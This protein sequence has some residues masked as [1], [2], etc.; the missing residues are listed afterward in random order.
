LRAV[1]IILL[2]LAVCDPRGYA[3][4]L[5]LEV[6]VDPRVELLSAAMCQSEWIRAIP[7]WLSS[8]AREMQQASFPYRSHPA[9]QR[10]NALHKRGVVIRDL[11]AWVLCYGPPPALE[12]RIKAS[13]EFVEKAGGQAAADN[14]AASLRRFAQD[15]RFSEF[16]AGHRAFY[17]SLIADYRANRPG[18]EA[19]DRL[20][21]FYGV[22]V[23]TFTILLAPLFGRFDHVQGNEEPDGGWRLYALDQPQALQDGKLVFDTERTRDF[24]FVQFGRGLAALAAQSVPAERRR[25]HA[26]WFAYVGKKLRRLG[27][28]G[29]DDAIV[30]S[31]ARACAV[32]LWLAQDD[33]GTAARLMR[34]SI[35]AGFAWLPFLV[36][37]VKEYEAARDKYPAFKDFAGRMFDALD[38]LEPTFT[39]GEPLDL[40]LADVGLTDDGVPVF[41]VTPGSPAAKAGIRAN[42]IVT[43]I[44]GIRINGSE[45]YLKAW[46][47]WE[48]SEEGERVAFGV[49]R[50][51]GKLTLTVVMRRAKTF[52]GFRKKE[53]GTP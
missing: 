43:S 20:A 5:R 50:G 36:E 39:P 30:Y 25:R 27:V 26:D 37:R 14:L 21:R 32:R 33:K 41:K 46:H 24:V 31:I 48:A 34:A 18:P 9:V 3:Q 10:L 49:L 6:E 35:E 12:P 29:W 28:T 40:G 13:A 53:S 44:A 23:D 51:A 45:S 38:E 22:K 47:R 4:G 42:D 11:M 7:T 52:E 2:C 8:Y 15:I 17:D 1:L 16:F 19:A